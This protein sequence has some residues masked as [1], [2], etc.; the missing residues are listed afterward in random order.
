LQFGRVLKALKRKPV[1]FLNTC[2]KINN[3]A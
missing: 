3:K 1:A 2:K